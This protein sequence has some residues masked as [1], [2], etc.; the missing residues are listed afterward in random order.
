MIRILLL[1]SFVA[2]CFAVPPIW[3]EDGP[4]GDSKYEDAGE[5]FLPPGSKIVGGI[6]ARPHEFPWQAS[7]RRR[8]SNGHFC[9]GFIINRF[10]IMTAAHCMIGETPAITIAVIGDHIRN[11]ADNPSRQSR[12]LSQIH[13]HPLYDD[14][15]FEYDI[16]LIKTVDPIFFHNDLQPICAPD[17]SS[18]YA[19]QK[20]VCSGWGTLSPGGACC[21]QTLQYVSMNI[22]TNAYCDAQY[23]FYTVYDDMICATDNTG[24]RERDSC[25]GDSGGPL[26]VKNAD[27]TFTVIGIVSWGIGCASGYPGVY[28]RV[29]YYQD[30]IMD[31][32]QN[33]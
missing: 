7:I 15:T 17:A 2:A 27:G 21:P 26:A 29:S 14:D 4:C 23:P 25:Q 24:S 33:N 16:A 6:A 3:F 31:T 28:A 22:T 8:S 11:E 9:G 5:M 1:S 18:D 12:D 10:W 32:I 30:W 20:S 19:Y 13:I